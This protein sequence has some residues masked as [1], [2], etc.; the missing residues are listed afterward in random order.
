MPRQP[1]LERPAPSAHAVGATPRHA[2]RGGRRAWPTTWS[3]TPGCR[4]PDVCFTAERRPG[5]A[6]APAGD[7]RSPTST[8]RAPPWSRAAAGRRARGRRSPATWAPPS[9]S[10]SSSSPGRASQRV[11]MARE[12]Y[13]SQ[14][15]F[16]EAL[17][18]CERAA[19]RTSRSAAALRALSR[20]GRGL[21]ARRHR[22]R[23]ARAVRDR[24]GAGRAVAGV[25]RHAGRGARPQRGRVRRRVRGRACARSRTG[26]ASSPSAAGSCRRC[27]AR[28]RWRRIFAGEDVVAAALRGRSTRR[29]RSPP[30]TGPSTRSS[31]DA[32]PPSPRCWPSS[33]RRASAAR[34][35]TSRTPSTRRCS[36]PMLEPLE[37]LA[38]TV[39]WARPR[40]GVVSNLT[41]DFAR[42]GE[43]ASGDVLAPSRARAGPLRRRRARARRRRAHGVPRDRP[44]A[45]VARHGGSLSVR[46][47]GRVAALAPAR[48]RRLGDDAR[49][50][51]G[52]VDARCRPSTGTASSAATGGGASRCRPRRSGA[53]ATGW[54][55]PPA[56]RAAPRDRAGRCIR[57]SASDSARRSTPRSSS[58]RSARG[59]SPTSASIASTAWRWR[60]RRPSS[61][62]R[63]RR[64]VHRAGFAPSAIENLRILSPLPFPD[65][66]QRVVQVL[67]TPDA[68]PAPPS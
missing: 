64:P 66:G 25:G 62:W 42:D 34:R 19:A 21:A 29:R 28:E 50:S 2:A 35:S 3:A 43:L 11:G 61:R 39:A 45:D 27:R 20:A 15:V 26:S 1:A 30:S 18:R 13:E 55:R 47:R 22:L 6:R 65:D 9:P 7:R 59:S 12:L 33:R 57:C 16:R 14:P 48:P 63:S 5:A 60:R 32:R 44:G 52:A 53:S 54:R 58:P 68:D 8:R 31:R 49:Q 36:S 10:P 4:S 67:A 41:G 23:A 24:V 40:I 51:G 56:A 17:E 38:E 37:R 46:W